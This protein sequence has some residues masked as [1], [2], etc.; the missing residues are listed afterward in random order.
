MS[1]GKDGEK[2][3]MFEDTF[4]ILDKVFKPFCVPQ[5]T[6]DLHDSITKNHESYLRMI[7]KNSNDDIKPIR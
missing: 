6:N 5:D 7:Q 2:N 1:F 4:K 3:N